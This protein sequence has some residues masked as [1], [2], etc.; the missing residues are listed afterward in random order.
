MKSFQAELSPLGHLPANS[1]GITNYSETATLKCDIRLLF[2]NVEHEERNV[3][4]GLL[5]GIN[6]M[7]ERS[8]SKHPSI[9]HAMTVILDV[10]GPLSNFRHELESKFYYWISTR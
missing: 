1:G 3:K 7:L 10:N 6:L 9:Q 8:A 4:L 2:V 5:H